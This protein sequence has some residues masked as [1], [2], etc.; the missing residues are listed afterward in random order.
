LFLAAVCLSAVGLPAWS[1]LPPGAKPLETASFHQ[2]FMDFAV[3]AAGPRSLVSPVFPAGIR[4][5][6]PKHAY[7]ADWRHGGVAFG[8]NYGNALATRSARETGRFLASAALHEDFRYRP[9]TS[10]NAAARFAHAVA[11][12]FV[13]R[14]D[15]GGNRLAISN[16]VAAG[17]GGF[18][19]N[20]YLPR[21]FNNASHA[22][23]RVALEFASL[24]GG[25]VMKEFGPDLGRLLAKLKLPALNI[26]IPE[27][28]VKR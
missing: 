19:G 9:S 2:K 10:S 3:A 20:L 4:L 14:S 28:W 22:E 16:F 1:Q 23:T 26:P 15:S 12:T 18:V 11:F 24:V 13:D 6:N 25:N 27:W 7:P 8:R 21:G 5:L 17:A